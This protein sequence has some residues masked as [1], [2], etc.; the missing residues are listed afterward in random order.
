MYFFC[1]QLVV[2]CVYILIAAAILVGCGYLLIL[3][4]SLIKEIYGIYEQHGKK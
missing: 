2:F 1:S 4:W 3:V